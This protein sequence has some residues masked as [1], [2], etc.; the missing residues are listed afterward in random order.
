M[1]A[2]VRGQHHAI[3]SAAG[4]LVALD[5]RAIWSKEDAYLLK[6]AGWDLDFRTEH[7]Q[8]A[9]RA[10]LRQQ[11]YL[12]RTV[13][14]IRSQ[15]DE[16]RIVGAGV[17]VGVNLHIGYGH[18]HMAV[19]SVGCRASWWV[20]DGKIHECGLGAATAPATPRDY[21]SSHDQSTTRDYQKIAVHSFSLLA[22]K[23][24]RG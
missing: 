15:V 10:C 6:S 16:T 2:A 7:R 24:R 13:L 14:Q 1:D 23:N 9:F 19:R 22:A 18:K 8:E 5:G 20:A 21:D 12:L 11:V 4:A 3:R 17:G